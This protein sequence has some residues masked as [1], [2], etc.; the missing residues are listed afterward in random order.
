MN[1]YAK[2]Q[3]HLARHAYKRGKNKGHA[4]L[5]GSRRGRSHERVVARTDHMAVH[6][7]NT[8]VIR[9]YPDGRIVIDCD[10]WA[11]APTTRTCVND[12][13]RWFGGAV[14]AVYSDRL[15]GKAQLVLR[16]SQGRC[17]YYDGI[18]IDGD[19]KLLSARKPFV[20]R[21]IDR[22]ASKELR[23]EMKDCGFADT[24]KLLH[25]V[26]DSPM[27]PLDQDSIRNAVRFARPAELRDFITMEL[28]ANKWP[29]VVAMVSFTHGYDWQT[30]SLR[31]SK[32]DAKAAW[33]QLM[34]RAKEDLYNIVPMQEV[35]ESNM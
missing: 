3:L 5:D 23:A 18:E 34:Q 15:Y 1:M 27:G 24:F 26:A 31:H 11:G 12:A 4:P 35:A 7:H 8:D 9:A 13:L 33:A 6:F 29:H 14:G 19:G 25:A 21:R 30:R 17:A 16:T 32:R 10:G 22:D 28:H 2:L 20:G